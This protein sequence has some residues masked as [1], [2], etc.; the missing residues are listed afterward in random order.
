M[1]D[2]QERLRDAITASVEG[3]QP[4]SGL[5]AAVRRRHRRW[6]LRVSAAAAA[7][8]A[9]VI[10]AAV[11]AGVQ[12]W[13]PAHRPPAAKPAKPPASKRGQPVF[14]GGGR[15]LL[16]DAGRLRWLYPDGRTTWIPGS[17]D[18]ATVSAGELLAWKDTSFGPSYY[19]MRLDGS[20]QRLVL[21]AGRDS[22]LSVI[23]ALLSPDGSTLAYVRQDLVSQTVVTDTLWTLDLAASRQ[24]DLGPISTT[25]FAWHD[26]R[27]ILTAAPDSKSLVLVSATTGSRSSYLAVTDPALIR[28]YE[29]ARPGAGPPAWIGSDGIAGSGPSSRLAV[30]LAGIRK[31]DGGTFPQ[32]GTFTQPAEVILAGTAPLVTYA[33][34]TPQGLSLTWGPDGLVLLRTGAGDKPGSWNA[35][36]GTLQSSRL[37]QPIAYGMDGATFNP[38]G[39]VIALQ[40]GGGVT[41][42]PTPRPACERTAR[43]LPFRPAG[44]F[45]P[46]IVQAWVQ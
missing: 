10:G 21:P 35:Y 38:A 6:L 41:F 30:W 11:L 40:D 27:T 43:C 39:N 15:L 34:E 7:V 42:W 37:S 20:R 24:A 32:E 25:A 17:F 19:M 33:P 26:N 8:V 4:S 13:G 14:P 46:G 16:A 44:L 31:A 28:A 12:Q 22:K 1:S 3:A 45:Q 36:V 18:G 5:M 9:A 29:Q 2:L 23:Q